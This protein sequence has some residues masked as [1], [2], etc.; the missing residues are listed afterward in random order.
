[1]FV[2]NVTGHMN[3]ANNERLI[4]R[5]LERY[6]E[7]RFRKPLFLIILL[8]LA[9]MAFSVTAQEP[10]QLTMTWWG[11]QSRHDRTIAVIEMYEAENPDIDIV[12]EFSSFGDYWPRVNT[13]AAGGEIACIMQH[14]Y[15]FI[16][17]WQSRDLLLPLGPLVESGALDLSN[18]DPISLEGSTIDE[19]LWGLS[20]GSNSQSIMIDTDLVAQAGL[21]MP[22]NDWTW[23]DFET[24]ALALHE[25]L[26]IWAIGPALDDEALWKSLYLGYGEWAFN[27]EGTALGYEDDQPLIE[28]FNMILRLQEAGAIP[29]AAEGAEIDPG[30]E[31]APLV[32]ANAVMD[33]RWSN[34]VVAVA[35]AAGEGRNF[36]LVPLPRPVGGV[37]SNY[38]KPSMFFSI[39]AG[40]AMPEEAAAFINFF[41]HDLEANEILLAE[42]G[43]PIASEVREHL[44]PLMDVVSASTFDFLVTVGADAS[45][46]RPPDPVGWADIRDNIY[47]PLFVDPVLYGQISVEEGV[48]LLREEASAILAQNAE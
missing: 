12:Y 33:Y 43:V 44:L 30:P 45:P 6:E 1:M 35:S 25:A 5:N 20:L 38:I 41:T 10:S 14:D 13:Q 37:S 11:S 8:L 22:T 47:A 26:G 46:I 31:S 36:A 40:C 21:E 3:F 42:R 34:Q 2:F 9:S 28:H 29:S 17:E 27:D 16:S 32:T 4:F 18:I 24:F 39:T 19:Q 7:M 23:A 15:A 48:A